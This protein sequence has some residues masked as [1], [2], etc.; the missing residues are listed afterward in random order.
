MEDPTPALPSASMLNAAVFVDSITLG[1]ALVAGGTLLLAGVTVWLGFS[2][3]SS[4]RAASKS[5]DASEAAV[6]AAL[7]NI[8]IDRQGVAAS[9][10]NA[11]ATLALIAAA[12]VP[13]VVPVPDPN[14][15]KQ[16][17]EPDVIR[18]TQEG[19]FSVVAA[20]LL[21]IGSGPAIVTGVELIGPG[22]GHMIDYFD[23]HEPI[24]AQGSADVRP[25]VRGWDASPSLDWLIN[26]DYSAPDGRRYRTHCTAR[27]DG[28]G[29]TI[30]PL[31]YERVPLPTKRRASLRRPYSSASLKALSRLGSTS[32][33][34]VL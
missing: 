13:F 5:A 4:A 15:V 16:R 34:A 31:S 27:V 6:N 19:A 18:K 28:V 17:G 11:E 2:T 29:D 25:H 24:P 7:D 21:N 14:R 23:K 3:R 9:M 8:E 26:I 33:Q 1:D 10:K 30:T 12:D 32:F 20:R 22:G